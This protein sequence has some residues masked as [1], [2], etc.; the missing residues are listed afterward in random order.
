MKTRLNDR[1]QVSIEYLVLV[2]VGLLVAVLITALAYNIFSIKDGIKQLIEAY[3]D[4][5]I[6]K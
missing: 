6:I 3:R 2:G 5:F 4:A 1:A